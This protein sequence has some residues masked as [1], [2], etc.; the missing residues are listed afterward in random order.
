[1]WYKIFTVFSWITI[2]STA[3]C[4]VA[5]V[6]HHPYPDWAVWLNFIGWMICLAVGGLDV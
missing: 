6:A 2:A 1:M 3:G 5:S 4:C